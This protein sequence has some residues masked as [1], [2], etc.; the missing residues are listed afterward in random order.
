MDRYLRV[1]IKKAEI[2]YAEFVPRLRV[3]TSG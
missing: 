3:F 1:Q 2:V